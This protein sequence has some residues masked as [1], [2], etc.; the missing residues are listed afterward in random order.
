MPSW[1]DALAELSKLSGRPAFLGLVVTASV[2]AVARDWRYGL[3]ALLV[4]YILVSVLHLRMIDPQ[5][6][7]IKLLVGVLICPMIY[8]AARWVEGE[9]AHKAE[10]ERRAIADKGGEVP[11]PP[12]PWPVRPTNWAFRLLAVLL[13]GL[14]LYSVSISFPLPFIPPDLAPSCVWL[15]LVGL[16]ILVLTS[17]PLSS[18]MGLL[19]LVTGFELYF[20]IMTPG[21]AGVGVF[22][23]IDLLMG[24]A[25]SYLITVRDLTGE[26]L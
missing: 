7:L 12:L 25:I 8:W 21:L 2:I 9:R 22:A 16:L 23:A 18:G 19:T 14:V 13:L 17:E 6:A 20:D 15:G 11:L 4:Q 26:V 10:E 3:W 1:M 5:L 24:L